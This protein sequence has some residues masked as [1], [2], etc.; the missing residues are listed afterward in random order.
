MNVE[1]V[2]RLGTSEVLEGSAVFVLIFYKQEIYAT[3]S[4]NLTTAFAFTEKKSR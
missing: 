3:M 2:H 1:P 4:C